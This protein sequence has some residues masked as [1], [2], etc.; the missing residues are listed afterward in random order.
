MAEREGFEPPD[1]SVNGFQDRRHKPLGHLS[2]KEHTRE[3][4]IGRLDVPP[5]RR[6]PTR[7]LESAPTLC[8][9]RRIT[10]RRCPT[11]G[12]TRSWNALARGRVV[13]SVRFHP[14][15][16]LLF[17][18]A[19][20]AALTPERLD[21]PEFRYPRVVVPL[22]TAWMAVWLVRVLRSGQARS[23]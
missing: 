23:S 13:D 4:P 12:M 14:F 5:N 10:G 7:A 11:C 19:L 17:G 18:A 20:V 8:T 15:G 22:A 1:L 2:A 6:L 3:G 21:R 9:F 16:P